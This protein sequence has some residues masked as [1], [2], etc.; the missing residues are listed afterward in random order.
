MKRKFVKEAF[1]PN[2]LPVPLKL[3]IYGHEPQ[4][5]PELERKPHYFSLRE[6]NYLLICEQHQRA[7]FTEDELVHYI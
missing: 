3:C 6:P 5:E 7:F 4:M 1:V 2:T